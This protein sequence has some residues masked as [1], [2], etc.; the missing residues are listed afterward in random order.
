D[1]LDAARIEYGVFRVNPAP[2]DLAALL[3]E[4]VRGIARPGVN[5]DVRV[6]AMGNVVV[7]AEAGRLRQCLEN[8][9][10][11]AIEQ[12]PE[13]GTV[14]VILSTETREDGEHAR[15]DVIDEGPGVPSEILPRIF[16]RLATGKAHAGGLGLGLYLAKR[17]AE[18]HSGELSVDSS[19]GKG[20]RF[21]LTI[22]CRLETGSDG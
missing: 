22:P 18:L 4:T 21:R 10:S 6:Q 5:M 12:S 20:A 15:I 11:N 16:D 2:T 19:P 8:L 9:L 3:R 17:I 1:L 14:S 13:G 7:L